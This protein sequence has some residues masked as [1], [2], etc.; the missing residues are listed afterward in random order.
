MKKKTKKTEKQVKKASDS[1]AFL[2]IDRSHSMTSL[3][4]EAVGSINA[5]VAGLAKE[6]S[7]A[8]VTLAAFDYRA[9]FQ[10]DV[11]REKCKPSAWKKLLTSETTPRGATPLYDAIGR[12]V[13][14][15]LDADRKRTVIVVMT[16]GLENCSTEITRHEAKELLEKCKSKDW[17]VVFLGANFDAMSQAASLNLSAS[18]TLNILP[19]NLQVSMTSL[20][21]QSSGYM[22]TGRSVSFNEAH[23][24][25]ASRT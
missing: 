12:L 18:S 4:D 14:R 13:R 10:F 2:L 3:W 24:K 20:A 17:Q 22:T 25:Q 19:Q 1:A 23:R 21:A 8:D 6:K 16:D 5:Y 9:G 15:A 11:L 7:N